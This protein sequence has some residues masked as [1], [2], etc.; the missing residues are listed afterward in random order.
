MIC[1]KLRA[2][3]MDDGEADD[4]DDHESIVDI[5]PSDR[6]SPLAIIQWCSSSSMNESQIPR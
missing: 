2:S 4:D 5:L 6:V 3:C 1:S